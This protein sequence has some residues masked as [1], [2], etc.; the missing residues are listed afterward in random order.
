MAGVSET[1]DIITQSNW[2][3]DKCDGTGNSG[4]NCDFTKGNVYQITYQWLGFGDIDF[5]IENP[6]TSKP[7]LVHRI[8]YANA[9]TIASVNN[10][11]LPLCGVAKNTSNTS[12]VVVEIGSMGG[13]IEGRD[14][15]KGLPQSTSV[16]ASGIGTTETP[17]LTIHSHDIYQSTINRVKVKMGLSSVSVDGTKPAT[18]RV[19][20]NAIL[21]GPVSFS[22]HSVNTSTIHQDTTATGVSGG[23][24]IF[25]KSISKTGDVDIDFE[26]MGIEL[27]SPD[28]LTLSIEASSGSTDTVSTLNW[29]ELF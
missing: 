14:I 19:R 7:T 4:I 10:P 5:F 24:V 11:T 15:F 13:F 25:S 12:D 27:N 1:D 29:Q 20:K 16:E 17:I 21:T 23:E 26:S 6:V 28:L 18:I 2:N 9:N 8:E 22:P 3:K